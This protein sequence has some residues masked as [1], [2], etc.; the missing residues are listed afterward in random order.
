MPLS[1]IAAMALHQSESVNLRYAPTEGHRFEYQGR[2]QVSSE[3]MGHLNGTWY[4]V[5]RIA[6]SSVTGVSESVWIAGSSG[7]GDGNLGAAASQM[8]SLKGKSYTIDIN[9]FGV[10]TSKGKPQ[11]MG[12]GSIIQLVYADHAV[13]VGDSWTSK[14]SPDFMIKASDQAKFTLT[15]LTDRDATIEAMP[16]DMGDAKDM[17]ASPFIFVVDRKSGYIRFVRGQLD[18]LAPEAK[19]SVTFSLAS[20]LFDAPAS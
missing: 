17:K 14:V 18:V 20:T 8:N 1:L 2:I 13:K 9:A 7:S 10:P 4:I 12:V 16:L 11:D 3:Q 5:K 15:N 6:K 19:M